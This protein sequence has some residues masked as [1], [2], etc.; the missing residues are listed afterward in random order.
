MH[1][2]R[3]LSLLVLMFGSAFAAQENTIK[4]LLYR[5]FESSNIQKQLDRESKKPYFQQLMNDD[6]T[7]RHDAMRQLAEVFESFN[8]S[9][10]KYYY[11]LYVACSH[12][13]L[14]LVGFFI[15]YTSLS[16]E[17]L[18]TPEMKN[19]DE[20]GVTPFLHACQSGNEN[21]IKHLMLLDR[22]ILDDVNDEGE[23]WLHV[24]AQSG[25]I[26][27]LHSLVEYLYDDK[28]YYKDINF[29]VED[30]MG[31]TVLSYLHVY[32]GVEETF[33]LLQDHG[34]NFDQVNAFN[35]TP[36]D[37]YAKLSDEN[38]FNKR[39]CIVYHTEY[40]P[41]ERSNGFYV[42]PTHQ[43]ETTDRCHCSIL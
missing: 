2:G 38:N 9:K 24:I 10:E 18:T 26:E 30:G 32:D 39:Y 42:K 8:L 11:P 23:N 19:F 15:M 31:R 14:D 41:D 28:Y 3:T 16:I 21:L 34:A 35:E 43:E 1:R 4:T 22:D 12:G 25:N 7:T 36:Q 33:Q 40:V 17:D 29:N 5:C 20:H 13:S 27:L 37:C 6:K